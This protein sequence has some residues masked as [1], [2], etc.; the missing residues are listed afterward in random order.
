MSLCQA[1]ACSATL[2]KTIDVFRSLTA[3]PRITSTRAM[4][5]TFS[6]SNVRPGR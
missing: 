4:T 1:R 2:S 5:A 6:K 3:V